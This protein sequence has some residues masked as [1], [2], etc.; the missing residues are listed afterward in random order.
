MTD[1]ARG[2]G[3]WLELGQIEEAQ[4]GDDAAALAAYVR[5][6]ELDPKSVP[7]LQA[8]AR[9]HAR[10]RSP[11]RRP[12]RRLLAAAL[13]LDRQVG[14]LRDAHAISAQ[15]AT[16]LRYDVLRYQVAVESAATP[17]A[18]ALPPV[19][20]HAPI[21]VVN[22]TPVAPQM[23]P[24]QAVQAFC[25]AA[26]ALAGGEMISPDH[27]YW[28]VFAAFAVFTRAPTAGHSFAR[29][30][31]R[32]A[33]TVIGAVVGFAIADAAQPH[34]YVELAL[35]FVG[36]GIA[37]YFLKVSYAV[38]LVFF[39]ICLALLY[40]VMG[41]FSPHLLLVRLGLTG[42]GA[43]AGVIA[44]TL[45]LPVRTPVFVARQAA[46]VFD[47]TA[48]T[49]RALR[50]GNP[51][52]IVDAVRRVDA[53]VD[54]LMDAVEALRG[55]HEPSRRR[56]AAT[57]A[58]ITGIADRLRRVVV[59]RA[60]PVRPR[61]HRHAAGMSLASAGDVTRFAGSDTERPS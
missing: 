36:L 57:I 43:A 32:L 59:L 46:A 44:A 38:T 60:D 13:A 16:S 6:G 49:F 41:Q 40:S 52:D 11:S 35:L 17:A 26:L 22:F 5:A 20:P 47:A 4:R 28:A 2:A 45:V 1:R 14:A 31:A 23:F 33:G 51:A 29:A 42:V 7:A 19:D 12:R 61:A 24:R 3:L 56:F 18:I 30:V 55:L 25:G 27:W 9:L 48:H 34:T 21:P 54:H 53:A 58:R 50:A 39:T 8:A 15:A 10:A 37:Y